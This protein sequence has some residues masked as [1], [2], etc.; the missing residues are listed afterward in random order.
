MKGTVKMKI[1]D[2][3]YK[4]YEKLYGTNFNR[5]MTIGK[6]D[7]G[8]AN[9]NIENLE[10]IKEQVEDKFPNYELY[11]SLYDYDSD[12]KVIT[13]NQTTLEKYEQHAVKNCLLFR[14]R[15]NIDII[16]EEVLGL[17]D[18]ERFMFIRRSINLGS[19]KDIVEESKKTFSFLKEKFDIRPIAMFNGFNEIL[20]FI[21]TENLNLKNGSLS[22][23]N[24]YKYVGK[25][26][27]LKTLVYENI[28]PYAQVVPLPGTQNNY[29]RLYTQ[30]FY[31]EYSY[32]EIMLNSQEKYLNTEHFNDFA[33]SEK[34]EKFMYK[35]DEILS[36]N[37]DKKI[38]FDSVI[39][40]IA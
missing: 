40:K 9:Y 8:Y 22:C 36:K 33:N 10:D 6:I 38:D 7:E 4:L 11:I 2:N 26:L 14:F 18:I 17:E 15:Q 32:E 31:P 19:N 34:I 24:F 5:L 1:D 21:Y 37:K 20:L 30:L 16:R 23:Y 35:I 39:E 13:W 29:S 12:E 25:K 27:N 3:W 28:E